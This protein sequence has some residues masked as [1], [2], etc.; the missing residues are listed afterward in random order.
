MDDADEVDD[1]GLCK[2]VEVIDINSGEEDKGPKNTD[3][4]RDLDEF[5]DVPLP[6]SGQSS[7]KT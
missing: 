4:I 7:G 5:F 1:T 6:V 2:D 3:R